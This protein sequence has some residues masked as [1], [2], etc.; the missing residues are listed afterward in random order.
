MY[1]YIYIYIYMCGAPCFWAPPPR[2]GSDSPREL[3]SR[4]G[5]KRPAGWAA[6][7]SAGWLSHSSSLITSRAAESSY[8]AAR[9]ASKQLG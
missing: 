3:A 2:V 6:G 9:A 8:G 1:I 5:S 7:W 4:L